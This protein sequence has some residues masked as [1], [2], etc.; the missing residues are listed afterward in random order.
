MHFYYI[1]HFPYIGKPHSA[2]EKT[3]NSYEL[4]IL[5]ANLTESDAGPSPICIDAGTTSNSSPV[6]YTWYKRNAQGDMQPIDTFNKG[7]CNPT[8]S[9]G[10]PDLVSVKNSF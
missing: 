10:S 1:V 8:T 9:P 7:Q 5:K 4:P 2:M 6:T 3:C